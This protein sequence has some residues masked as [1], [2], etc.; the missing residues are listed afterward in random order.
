[1]KQDIKQY[2]FVIRE[3]V[4]REIKRKYTRSTL[5]VLWSVLAPLLNMTVM[6]LIFTTIFTRDIENFPI[7]YLTGIILW[8][9]FSAGSAQ[10]MTS[11]VDNKSMLIKVKLPTG[12]F[13]LARCCT[14]LTNLSYSLIAYV[15]MLVVFQIKLN[16]AFLLMPIYILLTFLFTLGIG[17]AL[18]VMYIFFGDIQHLYT[19]LLTLWMFCSAIFYP[20]DRVAGVMRIIINNNP[21]YIFIA[22]ARRSILEGLA[23]TPREWV[24]MLLW[25][26][27]VYLFGTIIFDKFQNRVMQHI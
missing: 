3:L 20:V 15:I 12:I 17:K 2:I 24:M 26:L 25:S 22:A 10:A 27:G 21:M 6:S 18:S 13:P 5:G 9:M 4:S 14:A 23:P 11:L 1:L 16:A 8:N 19:V 7:Y